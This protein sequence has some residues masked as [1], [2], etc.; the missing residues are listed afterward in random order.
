MFDEIKRILMARDNWAIEV[1]PTKTAENL[2]K[3]FIAF[4]SLFAIN[5]VLLFASIYGFQINSSS[6]L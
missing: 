4:A 2:I 1:V 5:Y 3:T 6:P